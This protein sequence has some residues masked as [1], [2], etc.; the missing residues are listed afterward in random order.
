MVLTFNLE[1]FWTV[2]PQLLEAVPFTL[3]FIVMSSVVSLLAGILVALIRIPRLPVLYQLTEVWMS[4][5]RSMPFVLLL[6]LSYFLLPLPLQTLGVDTNAIPKEVY[7]YV[8]M[9]VHYGPI[10]AEVIRPAYEA[11]PRGQTE[12]AIA[13]G[14]SAWHRVTRI[15]LPQ[16]LPIMLPGMVNQLIEIIKDTSL[17]YMIGLMDLMGRANLLIHLRMGEG[18]L[19]CYIAVA[20]IYWILI[21]AL[22]LL[23]ARLDE[24]SQKFLRRRAA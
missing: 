3:Y 23:A 5:V 11:V 24:H 9:I 19:E 4:F 10:I 1:Y 22:E 8:A 12:A 18:K 17:M 16:A 6:F 7:V 15:L 13:F 2:W 21:S 14:L 20:I